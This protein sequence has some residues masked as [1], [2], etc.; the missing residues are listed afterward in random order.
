MT[1]ILKQR[2]LI[3]KY[4]GEIT[5][6]FKKKDEEP[7]GINNIGHSFTQGLTVTAAVAWNGLIYPNKRVCYAAGGAIRDHFFGKPGT[8]VDF[9]IGITELPSD[10]LIRQPMM[11]SIFTTDDW[12]AR[13]LEE[14]EDQE[15]IQDIEVYEAIKD[16]DKINVVV[17]N[18]DN[19]NNTIDE[20]GCN[21]SQAY[22]DC[23]T[24]QSIYSGD[25]VDGVLNKTLV[26]NHNASDPYIEKIIKKFPDY[27]IRG[28]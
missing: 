18:K 9:F 6:T 3:V 12:E 25:F 17:T 21:L 28:L 8:D 16:D 14:G 15:Y 19:I 1:T 5:N 20:F 2:Q 4:T 13:L 27:K 7:S 23:S 10:P 22:Y 26:F 24:S 11:L